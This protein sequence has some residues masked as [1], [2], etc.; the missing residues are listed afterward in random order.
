MGD[1]GLP[2]PPAEGKAGVGPGWGVIS[3]LGRSGV[4]QTM[5]GLV[6][7]VKPSLYHRCFINQ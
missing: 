4:V 3:W 5:G 1:L 2:S 7:L 6:A